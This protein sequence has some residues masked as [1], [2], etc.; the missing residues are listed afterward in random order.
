MNKDNHSFDIIVI[1][2]GHAGCEACLAAARM[3]AKTALFTINLDTIAQM[4]CNP[5]IGG[6]AKGQI[7]K[8]IDALGGEM[9][10]VTDATGI[11]FRMLNLKKGPAVWGPRAQADKKKYQ[12][13]MKGVI[14][15][16]ENLHVLQDEAAKI[17][18]K[19]KK[20]CGIE[21]VRG[22]VY[23][24]RA[25]VIAT[26]TFLNG[27]IHIGPFTM[28][29]GRF[30]EPASKLLPLSIKK[31]GLK[32]GRL[33]TGTPTR[34]NGKSV[35]YS[36]MQVL[37]GD[38][39]ILPFS[40][41]TEKIDREQ[42]PCY[43][44]R[45]TKKTRDIVKRNLKYSPLYSGRITGVGVRY[46]PSLEDKFVKFPDKD[47]HHIFLEPEGADTTEVYVNG[48]SSSL[49]EKVQEKMIRSITGLEKAEIMRVGYAIEYDFVNPIQLRPTLETKK[50]KNLFLAGQI[51]GTSGYEEAAAQGLMAG[52]NAAL[53]LQKKEPLILGREESYIGTLID[54]LVTKGTEE[55]YRMF[56]SRS[57]YR[58]LLRADNADIRLSPCGKKIGLVPDEAYEKMLRRQKAIEEYKLLARKIKIK[59][60][61]LHDYIVRSREDSMESIEE[62]ARSIEGVSFP[63]AVT[64]YSD[65]LYSGYVRRIGEEVEK[66]KRYDKLAIPEGFDYSRV[67][68]LRK[69][70]VEKFSRV[71]PLNIAQAMRIS[72]VTPADA[73]LL[74][75]EI[76]KIKEKG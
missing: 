70:S 37:N 64:L 11:Q 9:G 47:S 2:A 43:L 28:E 68:G 54:D 63:D 62:V 67:R 10:R 30:S 66:L 33:K 19:D 13:H 45:T 32:M 56:T 20:V 40:F 60:E 72:G 4:S 23:R 16:Q 12:F 50:I 41:S 27:L 74:M 59:D 29:A 48:A 3:G 5:A 71:R 8:E 52:I 1:G 36:Q 46:C 53:G 34:I 44:T 42:M 26:G 24:T 35:D 69:E 25:L 75:M 31:L 51:N 65:I 18:I 38:R 76:K 15:S 7:V 39:I 22:Q 73:T 17:L 55:P 61:A 6:I 57:E 14:E 49:P 58:L 21:T